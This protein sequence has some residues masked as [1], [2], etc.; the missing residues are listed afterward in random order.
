MVGQLIASIFLFVYMIY[1]IGWV[2][3]N[4]SYEMYKINNVIRA[5]LIGVMCVN[6]YVGLIA[7]IVI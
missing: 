2:R 7:M 6:T 3:K 1:F 4:I 5:I